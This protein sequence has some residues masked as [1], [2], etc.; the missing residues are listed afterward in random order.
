EAADKERQAE[1]REQ[2]AAE[3]PPHVRHRLTDD[4][5]LKNDDDGEN[6]EKVAKILGDLFDKGVERIRHALARKRK[7]ARMLAGFGRRGKCAAR[8]RRPPAISARSARRA[9]RS[10]RDPDNGCPG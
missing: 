10:P 8:P 9:A 7:S 3:P 2:D 4:A 6:R 5:P 1:Q